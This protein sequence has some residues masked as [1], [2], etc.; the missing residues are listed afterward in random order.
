CLA[1]ALAMISMGLWPVMDVLIPTL[2]ENKPLRY[3]ITPANYVISANPSSR[4]SSRQRS[5]WHSVGWPAED[6]F[7]KGSPSQTPLQPDW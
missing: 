4:I 2:R 5:P 1:G 3:L 6:R 7:S